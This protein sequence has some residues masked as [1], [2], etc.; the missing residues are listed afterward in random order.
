M[1]TKKYYL[2]IIDFTHDKIFLYKISLFDLQ[3]LKEEEAVSSIIPLYLNPP[4][5]LSLSRVTANSIGL[6]HDSGH[7]D[8]ARQVISQLISTQRYYDERDLV[9]RS[10]L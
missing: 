1:N 5:R 6:F 9:Y 7:A 4:L 8:D 10:Y 2:L 3:V